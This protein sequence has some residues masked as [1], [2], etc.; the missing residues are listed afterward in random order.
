M[1]ELTVGRSGAD[2]TGMD[3]NAIQTA[4]DA[5]A[6]EGGGTV[7]LLPGEYVLQN[8]VQLRSNIKLLGTRGKT[9]FKPGPS[10]ASLLAVDADIG[11]KEITPVDSSAFSAGMGVCLRDADKPHIMSNKPLT[12][13]RVSDGKL[14]TNDYIIYD[15]CAEREGKVVCYSP[16]IRGYEVRNA[17]IADLTLDGQ[18]EDT[19]E[20]EALRSS[21]L[22]LERCENML[23]DHIHAKRCQGDG[24]CCITCR[25]ITIQDCEAEENVEYGIHLG[26]HSPECRVLRCTVHHN[27][28]DGL[29]LCWGVRRGEFADNA[30]HH[31]GHIKIRNGIS[32]GHKDT[33]NLIARNHISENWKHGIHF[34]EKT[35]ANGAHRNILRENIIEN[36]GSESSPGCGIFINGIT[37]DIQLERNEIRQTAEKNNPKLQQNALYLAP[38]VTRVTMSRNKMTGHPGAAIVDE[39]ESLEN[40]LQ[41][42]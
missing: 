12:V 41:A 30:I 3:G 22:C 34:R 13:I 28:A 19:T 10:A 6:F 42:Y 35:E 26:S 1:R 33:D 38:G 15:F 14:F 24:I 25:K 7:R 2:V 5:V 4:L 20:L 8:A 9:V 36:N 17:V 32:L 39:S 27:G 16:L 40:D 21:T 31:N 37:H 23:I 18:P 29:Y 11:E